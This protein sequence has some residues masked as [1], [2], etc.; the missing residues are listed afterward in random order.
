MNNPVPR[1]QHELTVLVDPSVTIQTQSFSIPIRNACVNIT[2][3][4]LASVFNTTIRV[5]VLWIASSWEFTLRMLKS[6]T[7]SKC[8]LAVIF[9]PF[10]FAMSFKANRPFIPRNV[11]RSLVRGHF[12][13]KFRKQNRKQGQIMI[14][15]LHNVSVILGMGVVTL[16][17]T[18]FRIGNLAREIYW[19]GN[20]TYK[21]GSLTQYT[22][23]WIICEE[24]WDG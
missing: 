5:R 2:T 19:T 13:E 1:L 17:V 22:V 18:A 4:Y 23:F 20:K 10:W 21:S 7:G 3:V 12:T 24:N 9:H 6:L 8:S 16:E 15:C 14:N 11:S